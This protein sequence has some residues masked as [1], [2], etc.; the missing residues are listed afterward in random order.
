MKWA[1]YNAT[2]LFSELKKCQDIILFHGPEERARG[3]AEYG[4]HP[5]FNGK[6]PV[7][8]WPV[9]HGPAKCQSMAYNFR[10]GPRAQKN[11]SLK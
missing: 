9:S 11:Y 3:Q 6:N 2:P 10:T 7:S 8:A 4:R 1:F 5:R